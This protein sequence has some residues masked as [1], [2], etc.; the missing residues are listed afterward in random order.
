MITCESSVPIPR[1]HVKVEDENEEK[2]KGFTNHK[3]VV[4]HAA[5]RVLL[6]KVKTYGTIGYS[7]RCGDDIV[8]ILYP[9]I[10]MLVADYEEQ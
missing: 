2:K 5:F 10:L 6:E 9:I 8:R 7:C 3:R 4:W 1:L